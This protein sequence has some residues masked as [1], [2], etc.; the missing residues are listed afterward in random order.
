[1]EAVGNDDG[2]EEED[3]GEMG[4]GGME[5]N[6]AE[7]DGEEDEDEE[8]EGA[9]MGMGGMEMKGVLVRTEGNDYQ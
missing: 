2:E 3:G 8:K 1:M 7:N 5:V 6:A 4:M 9:E